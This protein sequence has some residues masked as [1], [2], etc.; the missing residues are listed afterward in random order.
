MDDDDWSDWANEWEASQSPGGLAAR[1]GA[2]IQALMEKRFEP[3]RWIPGYLPEGMYV[4][5]GA[6]K[7][8]EGEDDVG[9]PEHGGSVAHNFG[10]DNR[11][12]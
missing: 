8:G 2:S 6:P 9:K 3:I 10:G 4:L 5:A 11:P 1:K 12:M 7:A